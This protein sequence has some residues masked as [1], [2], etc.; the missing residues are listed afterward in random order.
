MS[1][2][3]KVRVRNRTV[4]RHLNTTEIVVKKWCAQKVILDPEHTANLKKIIDTVYTVQYPVC[5]SL[6]FISHISSFFPSSSEDHTLTA[7]CT[8]PS[9]QLTLTSVSHT[10]TAWDK[11]SHTRRRSLQLAFAHILKDAHR[12]YTVIP[13]TRVRCHAFA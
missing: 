1:G 13:L 5:R 11:Q 8:V 7:G 4:V 10:F 12:M 6:V 3:N 9:H 2:W